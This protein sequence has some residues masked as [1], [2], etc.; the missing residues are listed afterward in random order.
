[1]STHH[2]KS[3][4]LTSGKNS[5]S[6]INGRRFSIYHLTKLLEQY[7][8][9]P[10]FDTNIIQ[11]VNIVEVKLGLLRPLL[12]FTSKQKIIQIIIFIL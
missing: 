10:S 2:N 7:T 11:N 5:T 4:K 6:Q 8:R 1:M 3:T 9:R 12:R